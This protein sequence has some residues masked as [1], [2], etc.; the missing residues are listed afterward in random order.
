MAGTDEPRVLVLL[1][2][3][4]YKAAV[5]TRG[6]AHQD[7]AREVGSTPRQNKK[8][9]ADEVKSRT[10]VRRCAT[11]PVLALSLS[12]SLSLSLCFSHACIYVC[13]LSWFRGGIP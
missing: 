9:G 8:G 11:V 1:L 3:G 2:I 5:R 7:N 12:L 10:D 6:K 13:A 4:S